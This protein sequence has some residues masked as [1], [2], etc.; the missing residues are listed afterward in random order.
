[1]REP[2]DVCALVRLCPIRK[3]CDSIQGLFGNCLDEEGSVKDGGGLLGQT[4]VGLNAYRWRMGRWR[5]AID[6][7]CPL[8]KLS[9]VRFAVRV[10][11]QG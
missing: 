1:M 3:A 2:I 7:S 10:S 4:P 6:C 5:V 11:F 9:Q 8:M